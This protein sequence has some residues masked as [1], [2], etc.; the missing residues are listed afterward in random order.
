[1]HEVTGFR[2]SHPLASC[3]SR[4]GVD[5]SHAY[6]QSWLHHP[7]SNLGTC[8]H[9]RMKQGLKSQSRTS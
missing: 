2:T 8:W 6:N 5:S 3:L 9:A 1:M 4:K 7:R